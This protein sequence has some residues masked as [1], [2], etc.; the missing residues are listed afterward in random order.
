MTEREGSIITA[1]I[2]I[3]NDGNCAGDSVT[4]MRRESEDSPWRNPATLGRGETSERMG[5][6]GFLRLAS[7]HAG[8]SVGEVGIETFDLEQGADRARAVYER[9]VS[10]R[11]GKTDHGYELPDFADLSEG[12]KA[13]WCAA[14]G[15]PSRHNP[16]MRD[17]GGG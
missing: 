5:A 3:V 8:E 7:T 1:S 14:G 11:G 16:Y 15:V 2:R 12:A 17:S 4:I 13:G 6:T 10:A 9:Y